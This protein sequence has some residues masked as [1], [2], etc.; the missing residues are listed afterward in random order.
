MKFSTD[1]ERCIHLSAPS[2][3]MGSDKYVH[4]GIQ[5]QRS[6]WESLMHGAIFNEKEILCVP[7]TG[8]L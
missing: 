7:A 6:D 8:Q 2:T 3:L 4:G 5:E 1:G